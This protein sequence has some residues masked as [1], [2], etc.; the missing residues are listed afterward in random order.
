V[1]DAALLVARETFLLGRG[2]TGRAAVQAGGSWAG[3]QCGQR[4]WN[5]RLEQ[6]PPRVD[7]ALQLSEHEDAVRRR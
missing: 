6:A 2:P 4:H 5:P 1:G 7:L 3:P